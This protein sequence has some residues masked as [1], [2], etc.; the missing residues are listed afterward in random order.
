V[1]CAESKQKKKG[2]AIRIVIVLRKGGKGKEEVL[3][4]RGRSFF[5]FFRKER[6]RA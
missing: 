3:G 5:T 1:A 4:K 2:A 6:G